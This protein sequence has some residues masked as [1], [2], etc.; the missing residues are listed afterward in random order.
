MPL[1]SRQEQI[2][3]LKETDFDV[4]VIGGGATGSGCALDAATRGLSTAMVE[5]DD[6]SAGTSS[7]STKLIHGGLRYLQKAIMSLDYEQYKM[8]KEAL[9]ERGN[10]L[11]I[12]PHLSFPLP[13]ML[14][15]YKLWQLPYYWAGIKA[16]DL[17]SGSQCLKSSFIM[18]K[19]RALEMFPMLKR[20]K[21]KGAIVYYDGSHN[22][23]RMCISLAIT[24]ARHGATV[25]N[26][27]KVTD[28]IKDES[29]KLTGAKMRDE[30]SGEEWTTKA[31]S[32]INA[33]GPFTDSIRKMD[34][35]ELKDIVCPS[36]GVHII[37]P[38]YYSPANMGL[39][40]PET[41]DGRVIFLLPWLNHT[42][43]GTTDTPCDVTS[44]PTPTEKDISFI[45]NEVKNYL[46]PDVTVRRGDVLSAWSG[47]R[48]LVKDPNKE[49]T[50]SLV[51]NH[52]I[53]VSPSGLVTI[54][55]GK[56]TT[57][58]SMAL[59]T[60]D[61]AVA[62]SNLDPAKE[63]QTDGLLLEGA[64]E[65]TPTTYIKIVQDQGVDTPVAIHLAETYGDRAFSVLKMASRTGQ[66][67]PIIG[68]RLHPEYPYIEAEVR[69]AVREYAMT[70][71]DVISRRLRIAFLNAKAA[72]ETL[73]R[74]IDI[75]AEELNWSKAEKAKQME[76]AVYFLKTQMGQD[77]NRAAKESI[78]IT[79]TKSEVAEYV[80]R[81][82]NLDKERKGYLTVN[83][84]RTIL[85]VSTF[86]VIHQF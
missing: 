76:E 38:D 34:N 70:A 46:S 1:P 12:A 3:K 31:K 32:V 35:Q 9:H 53:H 59:E 56:W 37:L 78:P 50:Q 23:A 39:I 10:L 79:L 83:D 25:A 64:H 26:H 30:I 48:P 14:P 4:L 19:E 68:K 33:T 8:V 82:N 71:V 11:D 20:D 22:D 66:R 49:D 51:R 43:A 16:Y 77:A 5:A 84:I 73:P 6:F 41:S 13:I 45:L 67:F 54:A 42:I 65:W 69:Y 62:A 55:G 24:A 80:R 75:M 2:K 36:A 60:I 18:S 15:V 17:V 47:I 57:Y 81:F 44:S 40:D 63:S 86:F 85:K 72:E 58:R 21:L 27:V 29:G 74:I 7:R 61:A 52:V 28:L